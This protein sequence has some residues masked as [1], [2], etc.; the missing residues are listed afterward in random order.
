MEFKAVKNH[1][2]RA[3]SQHKRQRLLQIWLPLGLA[4]G[5]VFGGAIW[6]AVAAGSPGPSLTKYADISAIWLILPLCLMGILFLIVLAALI[7]L[8]GRAYRGLPD[9]DRKVQAVFHR[10]EN[11]VRNAADQ[12]VK[13]IYSV[14]SWSAGRKALFER[15]FHR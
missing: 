13:P 8:T 5:V 9:L 6:A 1:P 3:E 4:I 14:N 10:I 7:Y 15:L 2:E 12:A 11:G